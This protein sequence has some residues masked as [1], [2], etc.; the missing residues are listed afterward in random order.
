MVNYEE[1]ILPLGDDCYLDVEREILYKDALP[2][3]LSRLQFR[4]LYRLGMDLERIVPSEELIAFA[5]MNSLIERHE[6]HVFI[7]RIRRKLE[8]NPSCPKCLLSVRGAGYVLFPRK[9]VLT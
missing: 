9:K 2:C 8:D 4:L 6:L 5:W 7:N 3:S 1:S